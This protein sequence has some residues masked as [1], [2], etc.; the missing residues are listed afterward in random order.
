MDEGFLGFGSSSTTTVS[1]YSKNISEMMAK[2]IQN[3]AGNTSIDMSI[4]IIGNNNVVKNVRM[5]QGVKLSTSC[6]MADSNI[7]DIQ[8]TVTNAIQQ[9]SEA[10][11]VAMLGAITSSDSEANTRISNEVRSVIT[12]ET[13]QNIINTYNAKMSILIDGNQ[14]IVEDISMEQTMKIL[15]DACLKAISKIKSVQDIETKAEQASKATQTNFISEIVDS[16]GDVITSVGAMWT[17]IIIVGMV[18]LG[19]IIISGGPFSALFGSVGYDEQQ[20]Q[21]EQQQEQAYQQQEQQAYQ[22]QEQQAYQQQDQQA[23]QQAYQGLV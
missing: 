22:Q 16:I 21:A 4:D 10:Q 9:Q 19:Y 20:A 5:V 12:R 1:I 18:V 17:I 14:N 7:S 6:I 3:C 23:Y 15:Q 13:L 11:N 8:Q 2:S